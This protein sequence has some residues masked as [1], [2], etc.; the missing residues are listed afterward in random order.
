MTRRDEATAA[1]SE[2]PT[3][4]TERLILRPFTPSDA[5]DVQRLAGDRAIAATTG[6]NIPHPYEDGMAEQWIAGHAERFR[7]AEAVEFAIS[8]RAEDALVGAVGLQL[9][10]AALRA[11]L[12]YWIG[13]PYWGQGYATEAARAVVEYGF[14]VLGLNRIHACHFGSNPA[15]G[16]VMEKI[17][18]TY[19]GC[20]R[21]HFCKW[22][23]F[24]DCLD[25][26]ILR[27]KYEARREQ[28][29]D[30]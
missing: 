27:S 30:T 7:N 10:M 5:A 18:M 20:R 8:K 6:G 17:G 28:C 4:H 23:V 21:Q 22:G 29:D 24:E 19:E 16:S 9:H 11:E 12:G 15:S 1:M 2:Q 3:L 25:Y 26:A 13:K 14:D